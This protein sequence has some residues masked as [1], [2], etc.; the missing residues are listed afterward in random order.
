MNAAERY[1]VRALT[2]RAL[3]GKATT[4]RG[5]AA[6]QAVY[7]RNLEAF[8]VAANSLVGA[9]QINHLLP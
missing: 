4:P 3:A 5:K 8:F 9:K 2:A 7:L 1:R 6:A